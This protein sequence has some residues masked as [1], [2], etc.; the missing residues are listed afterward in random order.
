MVRDFGVRLLPELSEGLENLPYEL[1]LRAEA[2]LA[3]YLR[4]NGFVAG[5]HWDISLTGQSAFVAGTD[6]AAQPA[7]EAPAEA[8][9]CCNS[10][11][12]R[13]ASRSRTMTRLRLTCSA[14]AS[15][16]P[17]GAQLSSGG[18]VDPKTVCR[19]TPRLLAEFE[20]VVDESPKG[21]L[22][23]PHRVTLEVTTSRSPLTSP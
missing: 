2:D 11:G 4:Q 7:R 10:V 22:D 15:A 3:A 16:E 20:I 14:A 23:L 17:G 6:P 13:L 9:L 12:A 21:P 19:G 18:R 1:A 8:G 5:G